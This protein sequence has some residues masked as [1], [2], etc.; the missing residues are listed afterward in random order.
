MQYVGCRVLSTMNTSSKDSPDTR[1]AGDLVIQG[2][3]SS[4][5]S[6]VS[7][8]LEGL[9]YHVS[10]GVG[11]CMLYGVLSPLPIQDIPLHHTVY[12][13]AEQVVGLTESFYLSHYLV[14]CLYGYGVSFSYSL[15]GHR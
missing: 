12:L 10:D 1:R 3:I 6:R 13:T 5:G 7:S 15:Q 2:T 9:R 11:P 4:E 8:H 14:R